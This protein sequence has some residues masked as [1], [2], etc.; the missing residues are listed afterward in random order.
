MFIVKAKIFYCLMAILILAFLSGL[1][2]TMEV[3]NLALYL[4]LYL[5]LMTGI[6]VFARKGFNYALWL[7]TLVPIFYY[8]ME[9]INNGATVAVGQFFLSSG[10]N[11]YCFLSV[12]A[13]AKE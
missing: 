13:M 4:M 8:A 3:Y 10:L 9:F 2:R 7:I 5:A 1:A 11:Y 6:Y 12:R